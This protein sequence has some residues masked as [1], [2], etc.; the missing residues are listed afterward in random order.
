MKLKRKCIVSW[1]GYLRKKER[2]KQRFLYEYFIGE[3][4]P[5]SRRGG[6]V[7]KARKEGEPIQG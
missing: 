2:V 7:T 1:L 3:W 5:G 6:Q 4:D